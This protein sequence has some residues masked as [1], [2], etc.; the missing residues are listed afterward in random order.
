MGEKKT[1]L[2]LPEQLPEEMTLEE[3]Q[4]D[5]YVLQKI[6]AGQVGVDTGNVIPHEDVMREMA[7]W[8]E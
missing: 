5:L 3:I 8:L 1:V 6:K 7:G 4:D 2:K